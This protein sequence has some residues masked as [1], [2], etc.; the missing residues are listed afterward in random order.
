MVHT[1]SKVNQNWGHAKTRV[2]TALVA[3]VERTGVHN[4]DKTEVVYDAAPNHH[5]GKACP[6]HSLQGTLQ[7]QD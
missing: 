6:I 5:M 1:N 4:Q 2:A 7:N 3:V